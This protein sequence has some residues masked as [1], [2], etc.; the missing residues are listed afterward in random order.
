MK[1]TENGVRNPHLYNTAESERPRLNGY[2]ECHS[3]R[4]VFQ[5]LQPEQF[6]KQQ[7]TNQRWIIKNGKLTYDTI[8]KFKTEIQNV[9]MHE[10]SVS[11][12]TE[13]ESE[14]E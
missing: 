8:K 6:P 5:R 9:R 11:T 1:T 12:G 2:G 7:H 3:P 14:R 13:C 4:T 10:V